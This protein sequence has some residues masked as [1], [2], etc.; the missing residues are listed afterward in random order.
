MKPR[1]EDRG[2]DNVPPSQCYLRTLGRAD[3]WMQNNSGLVI[4]EEKNAPV[5]FLPA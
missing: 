2:Y 4:G 3:K 1:F 5:S